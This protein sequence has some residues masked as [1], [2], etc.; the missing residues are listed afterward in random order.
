MLE[1]SPKIWYVP[2]SGDAK[3]GKM[4]ATYTEDI[5]CPDR[6]KFKKSGACYGKNFPCCLQWQKA[7]IKGVDAALLP[8]VIAE[9]KKSDVIRHNIAGDLSKNGSND[10]DAVLVKNLCKAY[11]V[12]N[13]KF[14]YTHCEVN[15]H[16]IE[17]V[18]NAADHGF[19]INDNA[20]VM[21]IC[22]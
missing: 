22:I 12:F 8:D 21:V 10:I 16:N 11:K 9:N 17:I 3:I 2:L 1:K 18:K 13:K 19:I 7:G 6:C 4:A 20:M 5:T 14:T 15:Q